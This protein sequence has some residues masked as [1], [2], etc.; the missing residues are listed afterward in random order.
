[1]MVIWKQQEGIGNVDKT[2]K[3]LTEKEFDEKYP[4][5]KDHADYKNYGSKK[6]KSNSQGLI[7]M[8]YLPSDRIKIT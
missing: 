6:K 7:Q 1:M 3:R 8:L 5:L 4:H 2:N